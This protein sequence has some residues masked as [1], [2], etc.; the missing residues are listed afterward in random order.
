MSS[1]F[2]VSYYLLTKMDASPPLLEVNSTSRL[3]N[4]K[5]SL[6]GTY[7]GYANHSQLVIK[8]VKTGEEVLTVAEHCSFSFSCDSDDQVLSWHESTLETWDLCSKTLLS[9]TTYSANIVDAV[10]KNGSLAIALRDGTVNG[11]QSF[12]P[13]TYARVAYNP[14]RTLLAVWSGTY[15]ELNHPSMSFVRHFEVGLQVSSMCTFEFTDDS[16]LC[17]SSIIGR[18]EIKR[19]IIDTDAQLVIPTRDERTQISAWGTRTR[20]FAII[21]GRNLEIRDSWGCDA[22]TL[23]TYKFDANDHLYE[24][25]MSD[26]GHIAVVKLFVGQQHYT[27]QVWNLASLCCKSS[28]LLDSLADT[29]VPSEFASLVFDHLDFVTRLERRDEHASRDHRQILHA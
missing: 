16:H 1:E 20:V 26:G 17:L 22:R 4:L 25:A 15:V 5:F 23:Q 18:N 28:R 24:V 10:F 11:V 21:N 12:V 19:L 3:T 6:K 29:F 2:L 7:I 9:G 27:V 13:L 14:S 8:R